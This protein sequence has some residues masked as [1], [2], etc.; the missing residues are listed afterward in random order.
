MTKEDFLKIVAPVYAHR[1]TLWMRFKHRFLGYHPYL[2]LSQYR[3]IL[4]GKFDE[5]KRAFYEAEKEYYT[6]K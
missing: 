6:R 3:C 5:S 4:C 2:L 1:M